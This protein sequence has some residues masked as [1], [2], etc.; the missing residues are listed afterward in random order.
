MLAGRTIHRTG[1]LPASQAKFDRAL[2]TNADILLIQEHWRGPNDLAS[3]Q[4]QARTKG[5][6]GVWALG[7]RNP[8]TGRYTS[9]VAILASVQR[10]LTQVGDS[11][12]RMITAQ[13]P[14]TR[15]VSLMVTSVYCWDTGKHYAA[16]K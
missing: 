12:D 6:H 7:N 5:W 4:G 2:P 10:P 1:R 15:R 9:G 14:W 13:V 11:D 8:V 16:K 3:W